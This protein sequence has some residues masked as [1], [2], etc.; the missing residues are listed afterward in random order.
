MP[1]ERLQVVVSGLDPVSNVFLQFC[2]AFVYT[3][4]EQLIGQGCEP[5]LD[6][7]DAGGPRRGEVADN[8][9]AWPASRPLPALVGGQV[10]PDEMHV[11]LVG[12]GLVDRV[13]ELLELLLGGQILDGTEGFV[14]DGLTFDDPEPHLH[15]VHSRCCRGGRE[16]HMDTGM[17]GQPRADF[18]FL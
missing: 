7:I 9:G 1:D 18:G 15:Q 8:M 5:P 16:M 13:E 10:V 14:V 3:T 2:N 17:F 11:Q 4:V 12:D 6:L